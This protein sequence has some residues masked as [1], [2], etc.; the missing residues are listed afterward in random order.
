MR[1]LRE[2]QG[3]VHLLL[4]D[5]IMPGM[6]GRDLAEQ[7]LAT[8]PQMRVLFMSGYTADVA[9][10]EGALKGIG[11]LLAKPFTPDELGHRVREALNE[12]R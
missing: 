7:V 6:N 5:V 11:T 8:H 9:P 3:P 12:P 2:H 4:T 1:H 10:L